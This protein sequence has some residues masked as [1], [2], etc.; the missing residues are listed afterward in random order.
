MGSNLRIPPAIRMRFEQVASRVVR[1]ARL[2]DDDTPLRIHEIVGH[3]EERWR[4]GVDADLNDENAERRALE[5]FG[6]P[7]AAARA[8]RRPLPYRLLAYRSHSP[9]RLLVFLTAYLCISWLAVVEGPYRALFNG[10]TV[11]L[12]DVVFPTDITFFFQGLGS[13]GVGIVA[14]MGVV[15]IRWNPHPEKAWVRGL[16]G[17]RHLAGILPLVA[18]VFLI[19]A[20]PVVTFRA[21]YHYI[22]V[23]GYGLYA[24]I[25]TVNLPVAWLGAACLV[26][27]WLDIPRRLSR[28]R[29]RTAPFEA[30]VQ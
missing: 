16:L 27:E 1:Q 25:A 4:E 8:L 6:D 20:A 14:M 18:L 11:P 22:P 29:N 5:L 21:W 30:M 24:A 15:L 3:L 19:G 26:S 28:R 9:E 12:I 13:F 10:R 7:A 23:R 2:D 17:F